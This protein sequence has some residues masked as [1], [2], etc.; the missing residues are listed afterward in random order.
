FEPGKYIERELTR[1]MIIRVLLLTGAGFGLTF[2]ITFLLEIPFLA[3]GLVTVNPYTFEITF[4]PYVMILLTFAE[5]GFIIPPIWYARS[6]GFGLGSI[7]LKISKFRRTSIAANIVEGETVVQEYQVEDSNRMTEALK[8]ILLGLLFGG[9]MLASNIFITW[10]VSLGSG[11]VVD[12]SAGLFT[13][14]DLFELGAWIIVMFV[15]V[16]FSEEL[17]F[18]GFLQ[19]RMEIYFRGRYDS[20]KIVALAITSFIFA[21][22]HLD[23][24]GLAARFVLGLFM[25]YLAQR[26]QYSI[27]GPTVAH[28]FNNAA[29]VVFAFFG[30]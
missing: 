7:G 22:M 10:L 19:R 21:S 3:F 28:G 25:G 26:R 1:D 11:A 14:H 20:Y 23:I 30:F 9:M 24:F 29:V 16:G 6:K 8:D 15:I 2:G 4:G 5:L 12:D 13:S 18:R 17:L 27:I